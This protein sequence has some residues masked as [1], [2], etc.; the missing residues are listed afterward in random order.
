MS[1]TENSSDEPLKA[2]KSSCRRTAMSVLVL[3]TSPRNTFVLCHNSNVPDLDSK[4]L[5][6]VGLG[7]GP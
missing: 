1:S 3:A 7:Q 6:L 2:S 5:E 4:A